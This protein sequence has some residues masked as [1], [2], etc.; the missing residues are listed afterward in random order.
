M[1]VEVVQK[2]LDLAISL[3][4]GNKS[5]TDNFFRL[6]DD[7][8]KLTGM[9]VANIQLDTYTQAAFAFGGASVAKSINKSDLDNSALFVFFSHPVSI[10]YV[11]GTELANK[12]NTSFYGIYRDRTG[13]INGPGSSTNWITFD[14][15]LSTSSSYI[16]AIDAANA[17]TSVD[18]YILEIEFE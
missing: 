10:K 12:F 3:F 17:G 9:K 1:A 16:T 8:R 2:Y 6:P 15:N 11:S 4:V 5:G 18:V 13:K 7:W 14:N